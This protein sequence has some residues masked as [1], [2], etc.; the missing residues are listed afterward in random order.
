MIKTLD[1]ER[2]SERRFHRFL[3]VL[4]VHLPFRFPT[5]LSDPSYLDLA[6]RGD[7]TVVRLSAAAVLPMV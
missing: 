6:I 4:P 7:M 3:P 1:T 5:V 2:G